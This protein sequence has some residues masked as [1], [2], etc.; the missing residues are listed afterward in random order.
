MS[1]GHAVALVGIEGIKGLILAQNLFEDFPPEYVKT[2]EIEH[3]KEHSFFTA[4]F[5]KVIAIQE[6]W[7]SDR[8]EMIFVAGLLH[9]IG[10]LVFERSYT[11]VSL[12]IVNYLKESKYDRDLSNLE[13]ANIGA[14]HGEAGA[15]ILGLWGISDEIVEA[16]ALHHLPSQAAHCHFPMTTAILHCAD[17]FSYAMSPKFSIDGI[18]RLDLIFLNKHTKTDQVQ[19]WRTACEAIL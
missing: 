8:V 18:E 19:K 12:E 10:R 2:F 15:Y 13:K 7:P 9:D 1:V 3:F 16:I 14:S 5:A 17:Q 11:K 6:N 4:R